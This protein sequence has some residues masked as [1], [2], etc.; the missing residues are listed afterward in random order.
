VTPNAAIY[1]DLKGRVAAVTGGSRGIGEAM[2][3]GLAANGAHVL[4]GSISLEEGEIAAKKISEMGGS[5]LAFYL[6]VAKREDCESFVRHAVDRFGS[7]DIMMCN[8]GI[9]V[10]ADALST[11]VALWD[12]TIGI[13]LTGAF[14][15]AIAAGHQMVDQGSGGSIVFTS[16]TAAQVGF[17]RLTAY[18]AAKGAVNQL[19]RSL[20]MEWGPHRIRVNA[21]A[22]GW[23]SHRMTGNETAVGRGTI[24]KGIARTPLRR[25]GELAEIAAPA[26]FLA[27]EAASFITGAV[28]TVDG[29]YTAV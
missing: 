16:S 8:A 23:T 20:A 28:L 2:A 21:I 29:G 15:T 26:L 19:M 4:I 11:D 5:A 12:R 13:D 6:D 9:S 25:V 10:A 14:N 22:P 1:P 17:E 3:L 27:S 24:E 18:S 7:L